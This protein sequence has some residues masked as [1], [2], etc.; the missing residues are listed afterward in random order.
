MN[1][2]SL[3][4]YIKALPDEMLGE[5][6]AAVSAGANGRA[7]VTAAGT[8]AASASGRGVR[9]RNPRIFGTVLA[10]IAAVVLI[11][12]G[13]LLA[14]RF[15]NK[16]NKLEP[17]A[18][19]IGLASSTTLPPETDTSAPVDTNT[20]DPETTAIV[21][22]TPTSAATQIPEEPVHEQELPEKYRPDADPTGDGWT[23]KK[24]NN[25]K[26]FLV[27]NCQTPD[28]LPTYYD[29]GFLQGNS[30][31]K[32]DV[33]IF[34]R[35]FDSTITGD[36][37]FDRSICKK[38][39]K[40]IFTDPLTGNVVGYS[41]TNA[42]GI[43]MFTLKKQEGDGDFIV[44][45]ETEEYDIDYEWLEE[46]GYN[47]EYDWQE[48]TVHIFSSR[49]R[50]EFFGRDD[51]RYGGPYQGSVVWYELPVISK[52]AIEYTFIVN[53]INGEN[54]L[55]G[56]LDIGYSGDKILTIVPELSSITSYTMVAKPN[57]IDAIEQ[58][59]Y[60]DNYV[61]SFATVD[62]TYEVKG[63][64]VMVYVPI[65]SYE[66]ENVVWI[67]LT[68][69]DY[70]VIA[71]QMLQLT[72]QIRIDN[73]KHGPIRWELVEGNDCASIDPDTG[74]LTAINEGIVYVKAY[75]EDDPWLVYAEMEIII[76]APDE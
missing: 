76:F 40:V 72:C 35:F 63:E 39:I 25:R 69:N 1:E 41:Y 34:M 22:P 27:Y 20:L 2:E 17:G 7:G 18:T 19:D 30:P 33:T 57:F 53:D 66:L 73:E 15:G 28:T 50:G 14:I 37:N 65:S 3:A 56:Y 62:C 21:T 55:N 6:D 13:V 29:N 46:A 51:V 38:G 48:K 43:A 49:D 31:Y 26:P 54:G 12:V 64:T 60:R 36:P 42:D 71:G 4:K 59:V 9:E 67:D 47:S 24:Q 74:L 61:T 44:S 8:G 52:D 16:N 68:D 11:V 45:L 58:I 10:G 70:T 23:E 32:N 75:V 5:Y